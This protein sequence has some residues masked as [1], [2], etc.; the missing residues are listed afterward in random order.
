[1]AVLVLPGLMH[2][3]EKML[4]VLPSAGIAANPSWWQFLFLF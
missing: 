3:N 1:L 4:M 2:S